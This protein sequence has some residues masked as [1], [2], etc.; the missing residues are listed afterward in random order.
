[1]NA[2]QPRRLAGAALILASLATAVPARAQLV[3]HGFSRI[4]QSD[5]TF[6]SITSADMLGLEAVPVRSYSCTVAWG[7]RDAAA[8]TGA[9]L[10]AGRLGR[11]AAG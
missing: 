2:P 4:D 6:V 10:A 9:S 7:I 11:A 3:Y 5:A 1:M 8:D